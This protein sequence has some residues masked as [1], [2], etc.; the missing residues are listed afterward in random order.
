MVNTKVS[1][2][3]KYLSIKGSQELRNEILELFKLFPTVKE[4]YSAKL[5]PCSETE[6]LEKY[7]KIV[8]NEFYPDRGFPK[9]RYSIAKKAITDF[10]RISRNS[11][12]L[13]DLMLAYVESGVDCTM[14][15][16]DIDE[17]FYYNMETMYDKAAA[18]ISKN[19]LEEKFRE[20]CK[21]IMLRPSGVV[22]WGFSEA[23]SE[24]YDK[25]FAYLDI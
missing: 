14:E 24:T 1:E 25:Y 12:D 2:L 10:K 9:W 5:N 18:Y 21:K 7:K 3:K 20:R 11:R 22:G 19:N 4:Y 8:K 6:L 23:L 16:G 17:N 15:Y 13:A